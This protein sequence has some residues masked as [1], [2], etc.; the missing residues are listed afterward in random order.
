[1]WRRSTI[2]YKGENVSLFTRYY[3]Q[4]ILEPIVCKNVSSY[5]CWDI[6]QPHQICVSVCNFNFCPSGYSKMVFHYVYVLFGIY[7]SFLRPDLGLTNNWSENSEFPLSPILLWFHMFSYYLYLVLV[8]V[9]VTVDE[10]LFFMFISEA[11][12]N[13]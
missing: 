4:N 1:M 8:S 2:E 7:V 9:F 3:C 5:F 11:S 12:I 10:G 13:I 6:L